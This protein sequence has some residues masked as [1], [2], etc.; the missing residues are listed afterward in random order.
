MKTK[1]QYLFTLKEN[2]KTLQIYQFA[3]SLIE[4]INIHSRGLIPLLLSSCMTGI[5]MNHGYWIWW[6]WWIWWIWWIHLLF[7]QIEF[8]LNN[9]YKSKYSNCKDNWRA[10]IVGE[11]NKMW[12]HHSCVSFN[13]Y[14]L[15]TRKLPYKLFASTIF[16]IG[17]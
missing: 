10:N 9:V 12:Q 3:Q 5:R 14:C 15:L 1:S 4:L 11:N 7:A 13:I 6:V 2:A 8:Q 17:E 16:W